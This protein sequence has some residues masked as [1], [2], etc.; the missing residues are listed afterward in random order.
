MVTMFGGLANFAATAEPLP[1]PIIFYGNSSLRPLEFIDDGVTKGFTPD[2]VAA[3]G[4]EMGRNVELRLEN[5]SS[6]QHKVQT[7][8]G[9]V[10]TLVAPTP[11]RHRLYDFTAHN[12]TFTFSFFARSDQASFIDPNHLEGLRIGV[13]QGGFSRRFLTETRPELNIVGVADN[14]AGT[15]A[16]LQGEIDVFASGTMPQTHLLKTLKIQDIERLPKPFASRDSYFA[17]PKGHPVLVAELNDALASLVMSGEYYQILNKWAGSGLVTLA[18]SEIRLI[19]WVAIGGTVFVL[20]L[21]AG[22]FVLNRQKV[23]LAAE[24]AERKLAEDALRD[25]EHRLTLAQESAQ[26]GFWDWDLQTGQVEWS[27]GHYLI[28]GL[29]PPSARIPIAV[30]D[31]L[32]LIHPDDRT[33][34]QAEILVGSQGKKTAFEFRMIH[35]DGQVRWVWSKGVV[36][37][38]GR[39]MLGIS[40]DI[41]ESKALESNLRDALARARYADEAKSRFLAAASHDLRQPFQALQL[42][43]EV[44]RTQPT[45]PNQ[46]PA[47]EGMG[48]ALA[49]ADELLGSLLDVSA[50]EAGTVQPQLKPVSVCEIVSELVAEHGSLAENKGL[51]LR[52]LGEGNLE[53]ETDPILLKRILRNLLHNALRYTEKGGIVL[54]CRRRGERVILQVWDSGRG[55]APEHRESI[56]EDFFQLDNSAR[57]RRKGLGLGLSTVRRMAQLLTCDITVLSRIG[58]GTVFSVSLPIQAAPQTEPLSPANPQD[59]KAAAM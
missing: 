58:K 2:L 54:A 40:L 23:R 10:L 26:A 22:L 41:T 24:V 13:V 27:E 25:R 47:M 14:V 51:T 55:I 57:D 30:H 29:T 36:L 35:R 52:A 9:H 8:Q 19:V 50:L 31:I 18:E 39:R 15:H 17:V 37:D 46:H 12:F 59:A 3:L 16:L 11:E 53:V 20:L 42:F 21:G 7:G 34:I 43:Y 44:L 56:F 28:A 4:R 38:D 33:R 45:N 48:Q 6:A 49:A 5:W 32:P 1:D